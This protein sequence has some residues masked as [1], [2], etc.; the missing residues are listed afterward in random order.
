MYFICITLIF[1][2]DSVFCSIMFFFLLLYF[3]TADL[4]LFS[5]NSHVSFFKFTLCFSSFMME[6]WKVLTLPKKK[7]KRM[8]IEKKSHVH[9]VK[10]WEAN[11]VE[12]FKQPLNFTFLLIVTKVE[13]IIYSFILMCALNCFIFLPHFVW[14]RFLLHILIFCL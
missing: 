12:T 9:F 1:F 7:K 5:F 4:L 8:W 10:S 13:E 6:W 2:I 3:L 11:R 14:R